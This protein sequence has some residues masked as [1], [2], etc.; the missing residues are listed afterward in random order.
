MVTGSFTKLSSILR[1]PFRLISSSESGLAMRLCQPPRST[2]MC[3]QTSTNHI[4]EIPFFSSSVDVVDQLN[5]MILG[6]PKT[7]SRLSLSHRTVFGSTN[8]A[9]AETK[10]SD[11]C[12]TSPYLRGIQTQ[13]PDL[14]RHSNPAR[15]KSNFSI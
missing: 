10:K 8:Q 12:F 11:H 9:L 14:L 15:Q 7:G 13:M 5:R 6:Y 3:P 4:T 2:I 1:E